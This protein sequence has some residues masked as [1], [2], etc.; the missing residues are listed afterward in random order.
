MRVFAIAAALLT[1]VAGCGTPTLEVQGT[2]KVD[3]KPLEQGTIHFESVSLSEPLRSGAGVKDGAFSI[4]ATSKLVPGTYKATV[5][6]YRKT[7]RTVTDPQR[8][9]VEE[10][11]PVPLRENTVEIAITPE[12]ARS[13]EVSL[14]SS[15]RNP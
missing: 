14:S 4:A 12:N 2:V 8:G 15:A 9:P 6:G 11:A 1:S 5:E 13:V 10:T 7:G 3:G